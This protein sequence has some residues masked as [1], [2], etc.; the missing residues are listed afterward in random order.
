MENTFEL[1]PKISKSF[2]RLPKIFQNIHKSF[3]WK[4]PCA[5]SPLVRPLMCLFDGGKNKKV[6]YRLM[7]GSYR[8]KLWPLPEYIQTSVTVFPYTDLP[9][10][11]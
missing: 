10:G 11:K 3:L 2:W 9:A 5:A 4:T 8:E 6:I 7:V 1:F